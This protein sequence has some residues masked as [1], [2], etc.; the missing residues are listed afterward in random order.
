YEKLNFDL[1][2][3]EVTWAFGATKKTESISR[4]SSNALDKGVKTIVFERKSD[5]GIDRHT[6]ELGP[7]TL[8]LKKEEVQ[9]NGTA[10]FR[11]KYEF[12]RVG[13]K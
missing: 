8:V 12:Q 13:S 7:N 4:I 9:S 1:A 10:Q 2:K 3:A 5:K 11:N 6:L